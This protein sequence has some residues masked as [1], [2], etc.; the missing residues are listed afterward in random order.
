MQEPKIVCDNIGTYVYAQEPMLRSL[1]K[2]VFAS[3]RRKKSA[4]FFLKTNVTIKFLHVLAVLHENN[5][6]QFFRQ[7]FRQ[8]NIF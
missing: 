2:A 1:F 6:R 8:K 5:K 3:F 7:F 4:V